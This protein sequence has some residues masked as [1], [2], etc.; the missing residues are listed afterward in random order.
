MEA[1]HEGTSGSGTVPEGEAGVGETVEIKIKTLDSQSYSVRVEKNVAVPALKE[2][3]ASVVG[4]PAESQRLICRGKVLKDDQLLSAYNVEDGHTLHLVARQ[5]PPTSGVGPSA[6]SSEDGHGETG[7]PPP[8]GRSGHVSHSL[9][10]GTINFPDNGEGQMPDLNRIINAVISSIGM[11]G[12]VPFQG[13]AGSADNTTTGVLPTPGGVDGGAADGRN[14]GSDQDAG[15]REL[16]LQ[17]DA[18]YGMPSNS[19]GASGPTPFRVVQAPVVVPDALTTMSQYLDRLEQSFAAE[20]SART[21]NSQEIGP[22][23]AR[24]ASDVRPT[25]EEPRRGASPAA[26][27]ALVNRVNSLLRGQASSALS[28]L[29]SRLENEPTTFDAAAR[30]DVQHTAYHDGNVMQQIGAL[31]LELGRATLSLRMGQSPS[32][33]VVNS[34]PAIFISPTGPN[35]MMVQ[36]ANVASFRQVFDLSGMHRHNITLPSQSGGGVAVGTGLPSTP[37]GGPGFTVRQLL[38]RADPRNAS[39]GGGAP[40]DASG[41][42]RPNRSSNDAAD[43]A[44]AVPGSLSSGPTGMQGAFMT[45]DENGG[46][47]VV[48]VRSRGA[49][50]GPSAN[51]GDSLFARLPQTFNFRPASNPPNDAPVAAATYPPP[52]AS[53]DSPRQTDQ[54]SR[55]LP[56]EGGGAGGGIGSGEVAHLMSSLAPLLQHFAGALHQ[57]GGPTPLQQQSDSEAQEAPST[58]TVERQAE[59]EVRPTEDAQASRESPNGESVEAAL[60]S[61]VTSMVSDE[62][63]GDNERPGSSPNPTPEGQTL[64]AGGSGGPSGGTLDASGTAPVGLGLGG[65]QPL[66]ARGRRRRQAQQSGQ[67]GQRQAVQETLQSLRGQRD[68]ASDTNQRTNM[69]MPSLGQLVRAIGGGGDRQQGGPSIIGQLMRSPVV[70]NLVQQVMQ[71][72]GD[73]D[74]GGGGSR[75]GPATSPLDIQGML[76]HV[77][78]V[79]TQMLNGG[80]SAAFPGPSAGTSA[81]S[82]SDG[83]GRATASREA[84]S[85]RWQDALTPEEA[86]GWSETIAA[87]E[88]LQQSMPSQRPLSDVYRR[89]TPAAKRQKTA[90]E[91]AAEKLEDGGSA[92]VV[93]RDLADAASA[94]ISGSNGTTSTDDSTQQAV[95]VDGLA[96]AYLVVLFNDLAARVAAD[97]DFGDGSR[98]PHA[99][100][101]F[102]QP[103]Q[104]PTEPDGE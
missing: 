16:E 90:V 21:T 1:N 67:D 6:A 13:G 54:A 11:H 4:V 104:T 24:V 60:D 81:R 85:E 10:M 77:V 38:E 32:E 78:P 39:H 82:S 59:A 40:N 9:L 44:N 33:S 69:P 20:E 99:A 50:H 57:S 36:G 87:D 45:F 47:R 62:V 101:I 72:V 22:T 18:L 53:T 14:N 95:R 27:G 15:V 73:V 29:A 102:H 28:R 42:A 92:D 48:P 86:A 63:S 65:L 68:L 94:E 8:G 88:E 25:G 2:Q 58:D 70:E 74:A 51:H 37:A 61:G 12:G 71:G 55:S 26:L 75:R 43:G 93:L 64:E 100:R 19:A 49:G 98:F 83:A 7:L 23:E 66:P 30:D 84:E 76:Q 34:G 17:I 41:P 103:P 80:S 5:P 46:M 89:G 35:P 52:S 91:T 79:V 97:P 31:L 56:G 3:L 96:E